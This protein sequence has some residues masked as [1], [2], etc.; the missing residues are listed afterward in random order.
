MQT[1]HES[2]L[3]NEKRGLLAAVAGNPGTYPGVV[4]LYGVKDDCRHPELLSST[5][6]GFFGHESGF[7]EDGLTFW[8]TS[9]FTNTITAID[10]THPRA[11]RTLYT[12]N[13]SSHGLSLSRR[14]Q[15]GLPGGAAGRAHRSSTS[16]RSRRASRTRRRG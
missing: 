2:L 8:S 5:L 7:T 15:S 3:V 4:D 9:L 10:V 13:Y 6:T 16:R 11:P 1:P 14:R 12:G